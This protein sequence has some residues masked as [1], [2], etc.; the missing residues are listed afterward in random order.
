MFV[1]S[2]YSVPMIKFE[3]FTL[4]NGLKFIVHNDP[5]TTL[6]AFNILYNVGARDENSDKTGFAHLFE[7]LM[8]EGSINIPSYDTPLQNAGGENNAFTTNDITNYYITLPKEN[9]ETAF[10]LESDRML[11]LDLSEKKLE[12]QKN[13]VIEEF[14]QR[15]LNQPYGDA[16]LLLRPLAYKDHPYQWATIGKDISHIKNAK[17]EDVKDFFNQHYAPNNAIVCI[18]GNIRIEE[19]KLLAEKWFNPI[20]KKEISTRKLLKE[21]EQKEIRTHT[22]ERNVP[23][24]AI[25][26]AF[27][28]SSKLEKEYYVTDL[29]SDLLANGKS[30]RLYQNLVKT[31]KLFSEI[32]AFITGDIDPG[33]FIITGKLMDQITLEDAEHAINHELDQIVKGNISD[34]EIQKVKNKFESVYQ[35][36]QLSSLNKA[37][38]L[39]YH[40]LLGDANRI[41]LEIEKYRSVTKDEIQFVASKL[42]TMINAST[43]FYRSKKL[44]Q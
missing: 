17:L 16:M 14:N 24:N 37:I 20:L 18:A 23:F 3:K 13:V 21:P 41:N 35:F 19:I 39:S 32:N 38:D 29:I 36:G 30:S 8:F 34:Y 5:S 11:S 40:E 6:V 12:I 44:M 1:I 28:M 9:I 7:H 2:Q 42:F 15:Y 43:L 4:K 27:H 10:W 25:Y 33:L 31:K 22:V 26:K